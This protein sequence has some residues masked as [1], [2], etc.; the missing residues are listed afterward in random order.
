MTQA[1][2]AQIADALDLLRA[3]CPA[4]AA[5]VDELIT[6]I[7]IAGAMQSGAGSGDDEPF[8]FQGSSA[9]RAFGAILQDDQPDLNVMHCAASLIHEEAHTVLFALS[10]QEGVV[11][12]P[13]DER[14]ASPLRDDPRPMEGIFHAMF[15]LARMVFGMSEMIASDK[16]DPTQLE[17]AEAIRRESVPLFFDGLDTV[18]KHG[19]LT[20]QGALAVSEAEGYMS[21]FR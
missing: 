10:P 7:I 15:V 20:P 2:K 21:A 17:A 18:H 14:Y 8:A 6:T 3:T 16:L 19:V 13:D 1:R 12:N 4:L 9:L 5:E 11:E